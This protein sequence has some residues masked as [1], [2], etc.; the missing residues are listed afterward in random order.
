MLRFFT[1]AYSSYEVYM[2]CKWLSAMKTTCKYVDIKN[3]DILYKE[4]VGVVEG[5]CEPKHDIHYAL[6]C[7]I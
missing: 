6:G 3:M 7:R 5:T 2:P 4:H 1:F